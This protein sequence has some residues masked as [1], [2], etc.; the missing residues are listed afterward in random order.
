MVII[1]V[2]DKLEEK[3]IGRCLI[4]LDFRLCLDKQLDPDLSHEKMSNVNND[5][6]SIDN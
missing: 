1:L 5:S 4:S 6:S 2:R 3:K